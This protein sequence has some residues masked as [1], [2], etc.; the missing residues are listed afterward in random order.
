[1]VTFGTP[2]SERARDLVREC[3]AGSST[4]SQVITREDRATQTEDSIKD[5]IKLIEELLEENEQ[6][7][8]ELAS[9]KAAM[10]EMS[11]TSQASHSW[12]ES[13]SFHPC[14][15]PNC[16][17]G[18]AANFQTCCGTCPATHTRTYNERWDAHQ[19]QVTLPVGATLSRSNF[20][21]GYLVI[22]A[23]A[24]L[25]HL[26]GLHTVPWRQFAVSM[27]IVAGKLDESTVYQRKVLTFDGDMKVWGSS[28]SGRALKRVQ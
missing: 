24:H 7:R 5:P 8:E 25:K 14:I 4:P 12:E 10:E 9:V 11:Q 3:R 2:A 18:R 16:L 1:M 13:P 23:P 6:L 15:L 17:R 27:E 28:H 21:P 26:I 22:R 19:A 20:R